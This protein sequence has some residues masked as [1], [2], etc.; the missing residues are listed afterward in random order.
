M[1]VVD[2]KQFTFKDKP[3]IY[4]GVFVELYNW[5]N[6]GQVYEI[7]E[8][9]ELEKIYTSTA[10]NLCNFGAYWIIEISLVL[11]SAHVIFRDLD[12]FVFYVNNYINCDQ[13][14]QL[15]DLDRIDKNIKNA[16]AI[17]YKLGPALTKSINYKLEIANKERQKKEEMVERQKIE[18]MTAKRQ[19]IRGEISFFSEQKEDYESDTRDKID[20]D[21]ANDKYLLQL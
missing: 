3:V 5:R 18:A 2:P 8:M 13:F 11:H 20:P 21:Q 16:D 7:H 4:I 17:A 19:R 15:Y 1:T 10:E 6:C 12:K 14:N 9:I